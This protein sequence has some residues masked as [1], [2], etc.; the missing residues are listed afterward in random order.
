MSSKYVGKT[1]LEKV[2]SEKDEGINIICNQSWAKSSS[3]LSLPS[4]SISSSSII[5]FM[6]S[7]IGRFLRSFAS[8]L[9]LKINSNLFSYASGL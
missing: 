4:S 1:S 8:S 7:S 5:S 2:H 3:S 9:S 6:L